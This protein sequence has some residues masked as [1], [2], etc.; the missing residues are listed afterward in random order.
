MRRTQ[1]SSIEA[2]EKAIEEQKNTRDFNYI[3]DLK[4]LRKQYTCTS[5]RDYLKLLDLLVDKYSAEET[6]AVH[7]ALMKKVQ[8]GDLEAI[9]LWNEMSKE[10]RDVGEGVQIIVEA[11]RK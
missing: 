1:Q 7:A 5:K 8:A 11:P 9:R 10:N 4:M 3:N 2:L 6:A